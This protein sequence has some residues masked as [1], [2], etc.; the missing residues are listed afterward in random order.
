MSYTGILC[1]PL[2]IGI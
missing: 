2:Y 1:C